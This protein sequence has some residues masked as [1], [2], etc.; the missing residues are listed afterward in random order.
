MFK[1]KKFVV[2]LLIELILP[3]S[4][5][6]GGIRAIYY[7]GASGDAFHN[8]NY[9]MDYIYFSSMLDVFYHLAMFVGVIVILTELI[10]GFISLIL[11]IINI[12]ERSN[13]KYSIIRNFILWFFSGFC[14]FGTLILML[15]VQLFTYAQSV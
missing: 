8:G 6:I 15:L 10:I 11:M 4:V 13:I 14:V 9:G 2:T 1:N 12:I 7:Y 3:W 5:L